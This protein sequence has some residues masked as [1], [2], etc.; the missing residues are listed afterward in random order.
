M[1]QRSPHDFLKQE[2]SDESPRIFQIACLED[3]VTVAPW[4]YMSDHVIF[5]GQRCD[6]PLVPI[7]GRPPD[8]CVPTDG[9]PARRWWFHEEEAV[10]AEFKRESL[11]Y[12]RSIPS[13]DWQW[14]AVAQHNRLPTRL[15]DWTTNPLAALWFSVCEPTSAE[16]PGVVWAYRYE[17]SEAIYNT[18]DLDSPF[19]IDKTSVYFPEHVF[20]FI[21]A[22]SG[23]FTIHHRKSEHKTF[24]P[25]QETTKYGLTKVEIPPDSFPI[26]RL[27]LFQVGVHAAS[28]F[29]GLPGLV[30]KIKFTREM[31]K[32]EP[33]PV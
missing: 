5:R 25:F 26:I 12:L 20:P 10:F 30:D 18:K 6:W 31:L 22:Q 32:D 24:V 7:L 3:F 11:P 16:G 14:L 33:D 27:K 21:Q 19:S 1:R 13:T 4:L 2:Q 9:R 8:G 28:M 29:P 15:L 17:P 23:V